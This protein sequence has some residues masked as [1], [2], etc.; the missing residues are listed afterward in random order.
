MIPILKEPP[1]PSWRN[2]GNQTGAHAGVRTGTGAQ[3]HQ[4]LTQPWEE[5]KEKCD[6]SSAWKPEELEGAPCW[7]GL[8]QLGSVLNTWMHPLGP[9]IP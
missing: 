7:D 8:E 5:T 9:G 1:W 6:M 4:E 3:S 2:T